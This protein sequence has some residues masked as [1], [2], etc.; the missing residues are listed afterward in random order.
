MPDDL[1]SP[2]L[3][4]SPPALIKF[5]CC[6][7]GKQSFLQSVWHVW[8]LSQPVKPCFNKQNKTKTETEIKTKQT[9][10]TRKNK[11]SNS[12]EKT[13]SIYLL[14]NFSNINA[15]YLESH[16]DIKSVYLNRGPS[17]ESFTV[18]SV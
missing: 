11:R 2:G 10:K 5:I 12:S 7:Q 17:V 18:P 9:N 14:T 4:D 8:V 1:D 6:F 16:A 3:Q 15:Y 13:E